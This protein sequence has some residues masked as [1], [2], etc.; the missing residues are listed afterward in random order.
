MSDDDAIRRAIRRTKD[1]AAF[2]VIIA[3]VSGIT[4]GFVVRGAL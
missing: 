2:F 3:W 4:L 1:E